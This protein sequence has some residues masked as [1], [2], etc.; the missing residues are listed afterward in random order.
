[1][2]AVL[3]TIMILSHM[4][5]PFVCHVLWDLDYKG[6][7]SHTVTKCCKEIEMLWYYCS[8]HAVVRNPA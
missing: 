8:F 3:E 2:L 4:R 5:I 7:A 6:M 1:M